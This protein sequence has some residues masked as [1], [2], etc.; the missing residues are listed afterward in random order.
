MKNVK[1]PMQKILIVDDSLSD[2]KALG[3]EL[4]KDYKVIFA[5]SGR[6]ALDIAMSD[7]S[8]DLILLD[9]LMPGIGG[10][11]VCKRLKDEMSTREIPVIFVTAKDDDVEKVKGLELGAVDYITKPFFVPIVKARVKTHLE[12]MKHRDKVENISSL[13]RLTTI[14]NRHH[15]EDVFEM[16]WRHA[17]RGKRS[18]SLI[19]MDI[20]S[21][22]EFNDNYGPAAGDDCLRQVAETLASSIKRR[23]DY[24]ARY[25]GGEFVIILPETDFDGAVL[26]AE[27]MRERIESL[28]IRHAFSKVAD[29]ISLSMG[30]AG[31]V[32]PPDSL[33]DVLKEAAEKLLLDAKQQGGNQVK[34]LDL[35]T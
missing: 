20:D 24:V 30:V 4:K 28:N 12:L 17:V 3:E 10:F 26:V 34:S 2:I 13:D 21:F 29:R 19:L 31:I 15:F 8:P 5:T 25:G 27:M 11:E 35:R 16:E 6:E 23:T 33:S 1:I 18:M 32:P 7:K 14:P 22:T 9:I